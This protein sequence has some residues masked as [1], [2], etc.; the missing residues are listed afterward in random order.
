[1]QADCFGATAVGCPSNDSY[2]NG[3]D[4]ISPSDRSANMSRVRGKDTGPEILV[5]KLLHRLGYRFR[6]HRKDLPGKPDIVLP[7]HRLAMFIHGCFW[8]RH[9]GCRRATS[10][11]TRSEFWQ[12]KFR[13]TVARDAKQKTALEA[14]GWRVAIIWGCETRDMRQLQERVSS[15]LPAP[16]KKLRA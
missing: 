15:E 10:P 16:A 11:Q 13:A 12:A 3:V 8:H 1:M 14:A 9:E 7:R 6:L 2:L 5:R 4:R